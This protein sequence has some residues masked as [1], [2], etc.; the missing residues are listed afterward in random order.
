[1]AVQQKDLATLWGLS[2]A[3][4]S[5]MCK[6]G[7]PLSSLADAEAWRLSRA[8]AVGNL[9]RRLEAEAVSGAGDAATGEPGRDDAARLP[10]EA[11]DAISDALDKQRKLVNYT[12]GNYL[13]ALRDNPAAAGRFFTAYDKSLAMLLRVEKEATARALASRQLITRQTVLE[14]LRKVL[15]SVRSELEQAEFEFAPKAN[16]DDPALAVKAFRDF[17]QSVL[18]RLF[19]DA[20]DAAASLFGED[21]GERPVEPE[22][23]VDEDRPAELPDEGEAPSI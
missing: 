16:P 3:R 22:A 18:E 7:M 19:R 10:E 23:P 20:G 9:N 1:M 5:A 21:L 11:T 2:R 15:A 8:N 6:A 14:R 12:R 13:R 4:I 17:R